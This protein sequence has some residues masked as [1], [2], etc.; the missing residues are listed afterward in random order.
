MQKAASSTL[1]AITA[2]RL[3]D[4]LVVF[5]AA[6]GRWAEDV[7]LAEAFDGKEAL[8]AAL[9]VAAEAEKARVVVGPYAIDVAAGA[10]GLEPTRLRERI[11]A[12]GPTARTDVIEIPAGAT[13]AA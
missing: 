11:R 8:D 4:G 1:Q 3:S 13:R 9:A 7:H 2:N 12:F 10:H 5:L 6:G